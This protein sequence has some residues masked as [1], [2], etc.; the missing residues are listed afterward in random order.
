MGF[1]RDRTKILMTETRSF[2]EVFDDYY[3]AAYWI[4]G[5]LS[6]YQPDEWKTIELRINLIGVKYRA[7]VVF[8]KINVQLPLFDF[9][10]DVGH[11]Y[12]LVG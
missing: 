10:P 1:N 5:H 8:E 4:D 3:D 7:G 2:L 6:D 11:L 9:E 12:P